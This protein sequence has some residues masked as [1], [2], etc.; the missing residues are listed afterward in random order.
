MMNELRRRAFCSNLSVRVLPTG[1]PD[2]GWRD[3]QFRSLRPLVKKRIPARK[4]AV[5]VVK[6]ARVRADVTK[7]GKCTSPINLVFDRDNH[8]FQGIIRR[9]EDCAR[10]MKG[11]RSIRAIM[12]VDQTCQKIDVRRFPWPI[13]HRCIRALEM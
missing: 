6:N 10:C 9:R 7:R 8:G 12:I 13:M 2:S 1:I 5:T 11:E 4:S 3:V